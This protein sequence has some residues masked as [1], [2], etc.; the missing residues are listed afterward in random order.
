MFVPVGVFVGWLW[1]WRGMYFALGLSL[2]IELIQFFSKR[3]LME[4]D[5]LIH[6][7]FGTL[8]GIV[9]IVFVRKMNIHR[10]GNS[11]KHLK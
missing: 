8:I 11:C 1:K 7:C 10:K 9:F 5:D 6:N 2:S 3:G 4:I